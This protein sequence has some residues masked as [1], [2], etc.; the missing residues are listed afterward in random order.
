MATNLDIDDSL[1][2]EAKKVSSHKTKK[3]VVTEALQE[4]IQRRKQIEIADVFGTIDY[5]ESYDY[6]KQRKRPFPP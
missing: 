6:K 5:D 3:A 1:L 4:C 2:E